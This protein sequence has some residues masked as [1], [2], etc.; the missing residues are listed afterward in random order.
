M[1][2]EARKAELKA[3]IQDA[4]RQVF[5]EKGYAETKIGDIAQR[6]AVSP[7][8]IYLYFSGKRELFSSLDIPQA[9]ALRPEHEKR[10]E[11]I[12]RA[13]L[14]LFGERGFEGTTMD[15]IAES[16]GF[17]KAALYQYC[18]SKEDLFFQV[19]QLYAG[20][21]PCP[22]NRL[23]S[24]HWKREVRC[25]ARAYMELSHDEHRNAFFGAV[26]RDSNQF[27]AFGAVY[28]EKSFCTVRRLLTGFL[29]HQQELGTVR[30][31]LDMDL[32]VCSL[33]GSLTSFVVLYKI[34]NGVPADVDEE[35]YLEQTV[36]LFIDGVEQR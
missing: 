22:A 19:L 16:A 32:A 10:R 3:R 20:E 2:N 13:A 21:T 4:G 9:A 15:E 1:T 17:S 8:T 30:A 33:L 24:N 34:I 27:P 7:S 28:Y 36:E 6:A 35:A 23:D 12:L 25:V 14:I 11:E 18:T 26:I 29:R 5:L 31:G